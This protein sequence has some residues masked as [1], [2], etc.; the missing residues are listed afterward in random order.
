MEQEPVSLQQAAMMPPAEIEEPPA[1]GE[2]PAGGW[3]LTA[4]QIVICLILLVAALGVRFFGGDLFAR[5]R[6]DFTDRM[7]RNDLVTALAILWDGDPRTAVSSM[8]E[9]P[10]AVDSAPLPE[11]SAPD[12]SA[13]DPAPIPGGGTDETA[14][15]ETP[16]PTAAPV[17]DR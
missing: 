4:V 2:K 12:R 17:T 6:E 10:A 16:D 14:G 11:D 8:P 1:D 15:A 9:I 13:V 7:N 5:L 3:L